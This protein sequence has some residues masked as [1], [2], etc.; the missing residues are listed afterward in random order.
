MAKETGKSQEIVLRAITDLFEHSQYA[1]RQRIQE[2]THLTLTQVDEAVKGLRDKQ[3][4]RLTTPGYFE[5]VDQTIDRMV[6][7]T[8]LPMGRLKMEIG[9]EVLTLTPR[10]AFA[11]AKQLAGI[12]LAFVLPMSHPR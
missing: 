9:D 11:L 10:E 3:L 8:S 7:T 1:Y 12:L 2:V 4:I 6:S 5:P